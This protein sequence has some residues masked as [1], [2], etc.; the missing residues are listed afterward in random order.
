MITY[1]NR[2]YCSSYLCNNSKCDRYVTKEVRDGSVELHLPL[3]LVD[4]SLTTVSEDGEVMEGCQ[5]Y[6]A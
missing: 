3:A 6:I 4:F 1:K 5:R 2:T